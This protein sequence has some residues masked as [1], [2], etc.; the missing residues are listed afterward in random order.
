MKS[1]MLTLE[2]AEYPEILKKLSSPPKQLYFYGPLA[3]LL[4]LPRLAVVGSRKVTSYGKQVTVNLAGEAA[5]QGIVIVSGLA[6]GV[7]ALAHQAA[8]DAGGRT[9]AVLPGSVDKIYPARNYQLAQRIVQSG[10]VLL[11]ESPVGT[12]VFKGNFVTRNRI[13]AGISDATLVTE[14]VMG[15]GSLHTARF[16]VQQD[17]K[18]LA[19]PGNITSL[20]SEGTNKLLKHGAIVI[21]SVDDILAAMGVPR[22]QTKAAVIGSTPAENVLL[23][24]IQAGESDGDVLFALSKLEL[25]TFSQALTMLEINGL[26]QNAGSNRWVMN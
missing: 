6:L 1:N 11:S 10:G 25:A 22:A 19:V 24:L 8:L 5:K 20:T 7:D 26:I 14:A 13:I 4:T 2:D 21:T 3:E 12:E 17:K 23:Q 15:S 16:T 9:L 18:L